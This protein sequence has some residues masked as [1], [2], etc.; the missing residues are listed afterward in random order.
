MSKYVCMSICRL[1]EEY[2]VNW[3]ARVM[4]L[5][6]RGD[7]AGGKRVG[8]GMQYTLHLLSRAVS[9]AV[10]AVV[11]E[12]L[13]LAHCRGDGTVQHVPVFRDDERVGWKICSVL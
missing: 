4:L 2:G 8:H 11:A 7:D 1:L 6:F 12:V 9:S 13:L 3:T 10:V 5:S